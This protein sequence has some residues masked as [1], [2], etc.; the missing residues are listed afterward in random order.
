MDVHIYVSMFLSIY[1]HIYIL[2][3]FVCTYTLY[4]ILYVN[5]N[6][7]ASKRKVPIKHIHEK[8][9]LFY[10]KVKA[11]KKLKHQVRKKSVSSRD[12]SIHVVLFIDQNTFQVN[13]IVPTTS[14][15]LLISV[16]VEM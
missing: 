1:V 7:F 8:T 2:C 10:I 13:K 11:I 3:V 5:S 9:K 15:A 16:I 4:M 14:M 12:P 6:F